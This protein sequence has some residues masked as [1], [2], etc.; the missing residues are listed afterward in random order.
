VSLCSHDFAVAA[1]TSPIYLGAPKQAEPPPSPVV[2]PGEQ[3]EGGA[4]QHAASDL[5]EPD[6]DEPLAP[7]EQSRAED[8]NYVLGARSA[9]PIPSLRLSLHRHGRRLTAS[10][11]PSGETYDIQ[12]LRRGWRKLGA[13]TR[14]RRLTLSRRGVRAVRVRVHRLDGS[15]GRWTTR[16]VR[17]A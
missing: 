2:P 6:D 13:L 3:P 9:A 15:V 8:A 14:T 4:P 16:R 12:V 11:A 10:W 5:N 17:A 7:A 1:L